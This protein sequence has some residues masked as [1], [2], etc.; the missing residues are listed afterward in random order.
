M[1]VS[2]ESE[3]DERE[4]VHFHPIEFLTLIICRIYII[5]IYIIIYT[6]YINIFSL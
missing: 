6:Y 1:S 2:R 3:R 4:R 5:Y